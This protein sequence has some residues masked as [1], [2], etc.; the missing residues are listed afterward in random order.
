MRNIFTSDIPKVKAFKGPLPPGVAGYEF[1][2]PVA[3]DPNANPRHPWAT[4]SGT[5]P[6]IGPTEDGEMAKIPVNVTNVQQPTP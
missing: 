4:W 2:T 5:R 3:P 1:T 6:D